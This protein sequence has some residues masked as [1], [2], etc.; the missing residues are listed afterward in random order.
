M[1]HI[2]LITLLMSLIF[3][4]CKQD[5]AKLL[6]GK[7][8]VTK[9]ENN[10]EFLIGKWDAVKLANAELDSFFINSQNYIDTVGKKNDAATNLMLYGVAN[11][12]SMR[13]VL[14][15]QLDSA[16]VIQYA[17]V[18]TTSFVFLDNGLAVL[19]FHGN[20]DTST[21]NIDNE[22]NLALDDMNEGS[23]GEKVKMEILQLT[24]T[25]L[26]LKFREKDAYSIVSFHPDGAR[27]HK[28]DQM[29]ETYFE[30]RKDSVVELIFNGVTDSNRW[31]L[32]SDS[33]VVVSSIEKKPEGE[34]MKWRLVTLGNKD[35][36][37]KIIENSSI[38]TLTFRREE[39]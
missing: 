1:K 13:I 10:L 11:M 16:K 4:S 29:V 8:K 25:S 3:V 17:G 26:V 33:E 27:V 37:L 12:D 18:T 34:Q 24:D 5:K 19:S 2:T 9:F 14:Q 6:T 22:G 39:K 30:F 38:S 20:I 36:V 15:K 32:G 21:W 23:K 31:Y 28:A 35:L 7:W